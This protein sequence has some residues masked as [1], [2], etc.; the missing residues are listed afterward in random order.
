MDC[1]IGKDH[2]VFEQGASVGN[3]GGEKLVAEKKASPVAL[4]SSAMMSRHLQF[5]SS[6]D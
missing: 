1:N 2:A 3:V 5:P 6:M 4:L